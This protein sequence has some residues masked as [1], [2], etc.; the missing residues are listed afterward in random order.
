MFFKITLYDSSPILILLFFI[1]YAILLYPKDKKE[2][3]E[4]E[5]P[6]DK[7]YKDDHEIK[8]EKSDARIPKVR[9]YYLHFQLNSIFISCLVFISFPSYTSFNF[10]SFISLIHSPSFLFL[11]LIGIDK[12]QLERQV[13]V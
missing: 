2:T 3:Y 12:I 6:Y 4:D 8:G 5:A 1:L 9:M 10:C 11:L 13:Q 7:T